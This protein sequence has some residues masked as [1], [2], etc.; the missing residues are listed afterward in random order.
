[1]NSDVNG[2]FRL[3]QI[4]LY[5]WG[6]FHGLHTVD[7]AR[8]GHLI[9]GASGSGKSTLIDAVS[10]VL[11]PPVTVRFNAAAQDTGTRSGR[12]LITYCRGAWRREHSSEFDELTQSYLRT[13]PQWSGVALTYDDG[14]GK[15]VTAIRL[16]FLSAQCHHPSD[17]V[18]LFLLFPR[19]ANL[20]EC[21]KIARE[22]LNLRQA[23]HTWP[24]LL[25]VQRN[26]A[27]FMNALR[28]E[29]GIADQGALTLLHRTQSAKSLGDLNAL[30]R[31]FMLPEPPTLQTA[32]AA[33]EGFTEL[34]A[35]YQS[36]QNSRLQIG[37]LSPIRKANERIAETRKELELTSTDRDHLER[38]ITGHRL[39]EAEKK[40]LEVRACVTS[41]EEELTAA[42]QRV[43]HF[44]HERDQV[45]DLIQ[46]RQ[47]IG[48]VNARH[49]HE[50]AQTRLQII[51]KERDEFEANA[52]VLDATVPET[53]E[54][55]I[56]MRLQVQEL[57]EELEQSAKKYTNRRQ[58]LYG[59]YRVIQE[60][61]LSLRKELSAVRSYQS[62]MDSDL[63]VVREEICDALDLQ[64][65]DLPF[66]A[67]L[68]QVDP[69]E[70]RWQAVA[71]RVMHD[72][73]RTMLVPEE[74]YTAFTDAVEEKNLKTR[75]NYV[76]LSGTDDLRN[77][78]PF[79]AGTLATKI[80]VEPGRFHAWIQQQLAMKFDYTCVDTMEE[81]RRQRRA[82]TRCGHAKH[83]VRQHEKD[84]REVLTDRTHWVLSSSN[85]DKIDA[86]TSAIAAAQQ[87]LAKADEDAAVFEENTNRDYESLRAG[88]AIIAVTDFSAIDIEACKFEVNRC[89]TKIDELVD[90]EVELKELKRRFVNVEDELQQAI[91]EADRL[92]TQRGGYLQEFRQSE[93]LC[94]ELQSKVE[95][96]GE[97]TDEVKER[98]NAR[99]LNFTRSIRSDNILQ[100]KDR[101]SKEL[102]KQ[103]TKC[104]R[105]IQQ[106]ERL[107]MEAMLGFLSRWP[108]RSGDLV[109]DQAYRGD[110]A[111]LLA[112]LEEDDLPNFE[113]RF[114]EML[115]DQTKQNLNKLL[116]QIQS[117]PREIRDAMELINASL[118]TTEFEP[119]AHLQ[120]E[121]R[122]AL[123]AEARDFVSKLREV[124]DGVLNDEDALDSE[125]RFLKL[126]EVIELLKISDESP[127]R[128]YRLRLDTRKHVTFLGVELNLDG[129][130]GAVYDSAEG[131]S[132]GQAQKLVFF[133]LA[134]ALRYQLT[135]AGLSEARARTCV[136]GDCSRYGTVILDEAFDR[137]DARFTRRA[138]DVFTKFGFHMVL[139]TPEKMLQ[140]VQDYIGGVTVVTCADRKKSMTSQFLI[141]D[142][143]EAEEP[144][145]PA[146]TDTQLD[147]EEIEDNE[148]E[149]VKT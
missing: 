29:L 68:I 127:E 139:A 138:M 81:F 15:V 116:Y 123:P 103:I 4:Q 62:S 48:L 34:N 112:R 73:A 109:A 50:R 105:E 43:G 9:T 69:D 5:N 140:T 23:K 8:A 101:V 89:Q 92:T 60:R 87:R 75:L 44:Q 83:N 13:G 147:F 90:A 40:M 42:K 39:S 120:I 80:Q 136:V 111:A 26:H 22:E 91:E 99:F 76:R 70:H 131:L 137:A 95:D 128:I 142:A 125:E 133:C 134:A 18:N 144:E 143:P 20:S 82:V 72:F 114:R 84:D 6:T 102:N 132:G 41:V 149:S 45:R 56:D 129:S 77:Q 24:E 12:N 38:F 119:G 93:N 31:D 130:R 121:A 106:Q 115:R 126:K 104:N 27:P 57:C 63:L 124:V 21:E 52:E 64:H 71:E 59:A 79:R 141:Q 94:H 145:E 118:S 19:A 135:G 108:E 97:L 33:V 148:K 10:V 86:L 67:E 17:I 122:E 74:H 98:L 49:D 65:N 110:F 28:K 146:D 100:V 25:V 51:K 11:V 2:Q 107:A 78:M 16:M 14:K 117:A 37:A 66:I 1:M 54:G 35:A 55:F 3:S 30:M 113:A 53:R 7:I 61:L 46:G 32:A 85:D 58:E 88:R 96:F 47:G 36:V